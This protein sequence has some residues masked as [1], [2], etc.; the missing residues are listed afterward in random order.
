MK[1]LKEYLAG[2]QIRQSVDDSVSDFSTPIDVLNSWINQFRIIKEEGEILGL[3]NPQ[4]GAFHAILS[5]WTSS[6]ETGT[7]V[8]PTGT[9]KTETMLSVLVSERINKLLVIVPSDPLRSQISNKFIHIG[10]LRR[11]SILTELTQNPVV[12]TIKKSFASETELSEFLSKCNVVVGTASIIS[13]ISSAFPIILKE[14]FSHIFI[15]EAHH[16]EASS[17]N[18]IRLNFEGKFIIQFT[19][20]PFRN[21]NKKIDGKIIYNYPL[22][23]AQQEGYFKPINFQKIYEYNNQTKDRVLAEKGIHHLRIDKQDYPHILLARV[24]TKKRANEVFEIYNAYSSE[25]RVVKIHSGLGIRESRE[26]QRRILAL[27]VDIIVCVDMLGEGFD[28]P[29]L[30]IA[31]FH[32][33]RQSLP[34]TLQFVGRFTRTSYD[35]H[36]GNATV[37]ANLADVEVNDELDALYARDPDWNV[38][39]PLLSENRTQ[40]EI[41]L[42][43]FIQGFRDNEDFPVSIQSIKPALSTVVFKNNTDGWFPTN[44]INGIS[45]PDSYELIRHN[46]NQEERILVIVTVKKIPADWIKSETV[47]DLIWNFYIVHWDSRNNLLFIHS[48]DNSSLHIDLA[49]SIIGERAEL[50]TG[51]NGGKI[52][53]VLSGINRFKLQNV[54]LSEIIGRFIRFVMRVGTDIEP[55]LTQ[56]QINKAKKSMIYGAG[57]ENGED[58]SIGCSYKGRIWSRRRN[59][60]PTLIKWFHHVGGKILNEN[61]NGDDVLKG[62]LV[63]KALSEIPNEIPYLIDWNEEVYKQ[64]ETRYTFNIDGRKY[65]LYNVNLSLVNPSNNGNIRFAVVYDDNILIELDLIFYRDIN[66]NPTFKFSKVNT[67]QTATVTI[68]TK[69][70]DLVKYF[71]NETPSI[72]FANGDYMEGNNYYELKSIIQPFDS[73][74]ISTF[75]WDGIDLNVESQGCNPK[76]TNSIQYR[77]IEILK[78]NDYDVI[79]DD[80]NSGEIADVVTLKVHENK[81]S[82]ELYHLKYAIG[83]SSSRQIK[84]LYEVCGQAQKSVNWKF[85][86]GKEFLEHFLRREALRKQK[87][88]D[89]RFE[90]GDEQ[91]LIEILDLVNNR[92]PLE[93]DIFIVQPGVS[94]QNI[95]ADQL[96]LLG[97]TDT[98]LMERAAIRLKVIGNI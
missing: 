56:A 87:Q 46:Y 28:L 21:D 74:N 84:N 1:L 57:Y 72:W 60:I 25:F 31:V 9:G 27:D 51:D 33:I 78:T 36:L 32:D 64:S 92:I 88:L 34:I 80:D 7:V 41:D 91:K 93:F 90:F 66:N 38:I 76:K 10:L 24:G 42:Y 50:I 40:N 94:R 12:G 20:T 82:V 44:Y 11:L 3:R 2:N 59:D 49:K 65:E 86:R 5:H 68:G 95:T 30:K 73:N 77:V 62:A 71:Y 23:K 39:L 63:A 22:K 18:K 47:T 67:T 97:V 19:A 85:K 43:N 37:I 69:E 16:T 75:D 53:R 8:L 81:I 4:I 13:R 48:S 61:I 70:T 45:N 26:I 58:I 15:D 14:S 83:G 17:W 35:L 54:G 98:Y 55:A 89:S 29:N 79:F 96:S 52:F 6:S